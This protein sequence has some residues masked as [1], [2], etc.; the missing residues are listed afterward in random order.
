ML[1]IDSMNM[2]YNGTS[3]VGNSSLISFNANI[4]DPDNNAYVNF[5]IS[6]MSDFRENLATAK[7]DIAAFIDEI[8]KL[9]A[10]RGE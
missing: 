10:Q 8:V 9:P 6:N 3:I 2:N 1:R 5:S 7:V 4:N